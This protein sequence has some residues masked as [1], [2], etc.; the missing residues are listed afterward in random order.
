MDV[1]STSSG[2]VCAISSVPLNALPTSLTPLAVG[3]QKASAINMAKD[4]ALQS[5]MGGWRGSPDKCPEIWQDL[6]VKSSLLAS[7]T[8]DAYLC[9]AAFGKTA[10]IWPERHDR[11]ALSNHGI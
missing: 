11:K 8:P 1:L 4:T 7:P 5:C 3:A 10:V 6:T 9:G 2:T